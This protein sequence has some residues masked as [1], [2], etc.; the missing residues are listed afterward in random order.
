MNETLCPMDFQHVS[1]RGGVAWELAA[2]AAV[3]GL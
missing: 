3:H 1:V 2:V